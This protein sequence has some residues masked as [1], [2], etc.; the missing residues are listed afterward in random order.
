LITHGSERKISTCT[1][2]KHRH[3]DEE[4]PKSTAASPTT[5]TE[6]YCGLAIS[7]DIASSSKLN[8]TY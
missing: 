4:Q 8:C 2:D 6:L 1:G 7:V 3:V 5:A